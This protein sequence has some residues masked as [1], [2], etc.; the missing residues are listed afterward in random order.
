M[1]KSMIA[2]VLLQSLNAHAEVDSALVRCFYSTAA[3]IGEESL[4][5][6]NYLLVDQVS[7]SQMLAFKG[8]HGYRYDL[9]AAKECPVADVP[10]G[11]PTYVSLANPEN[12]Q[13]ILS[14]LIIQKGRLTGRS[15]ETRSVEARACTTSISPVSMSDEE[16]AATMA[17]LLEG[18][19]PGLTQLQE[20]LERIRI[21]FTYYGPNG[22]SDLGQGYVQARSH[23]VMRATAPLRVCAAA[24]NKSVA[25]EAQAKLTEILRAEQSL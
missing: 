9:S 21:Q 1:K 11:R 10:A 15:S 14:G 18:K 7:R 4:N 17:T 25:S 20:E 13:S 6:K 23:L 24:Q 19:I 2:L 12:A 3:Q 8:E 5:E 16:T 22:N